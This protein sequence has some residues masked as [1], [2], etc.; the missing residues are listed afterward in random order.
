MDRYQPMALSESLLTF[1]QNLFFKKI[2]VSLVLWT[3]FVLPSPID[4]LKSLCTLSPDCSFEK[5]G[6][7]ALWLV[8][9]EVAP[10]FAFLNFF[11]GTFIN[12]IF[13]YF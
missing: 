2:F 8:S 4:S 5:L 1:I 11:E 13:L 6:L 10:N 3:V 9:R 12:D 7:R